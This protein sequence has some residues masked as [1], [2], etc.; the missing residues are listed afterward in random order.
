[1]N[2]PFCRNQLT[3]FSFHSIFGPLFLFKKHFTFITLCNFSHNDLR[4]VAHPNVLT[5]Y[6]IYINDKQEQFMATEFMNEGDLL[7]VLHRE[8]ELTIE[9]LVSFA[10]QSAQGMEHLHSHGILH[11]D[12][13]CRNLLVSRLDSYIVKIADLGLRFKDFFV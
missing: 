7:G 9:D 5:F 4:N 11:R 1:M 13:A 8:A 10:K 3:T 12:L 6:G 2:S